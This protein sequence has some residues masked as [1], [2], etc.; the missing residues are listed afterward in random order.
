MRRV[1]F[2]R[3]KKEET[4]ELVLNRLSGKTDIL[5]APVWTGKKWVVWMLTQD[6]Q[7]KSGDVD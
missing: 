7:I 1:V 4:V 2:I 3:S 5:G 6:E